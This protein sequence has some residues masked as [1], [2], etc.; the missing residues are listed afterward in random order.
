MNKLEKWGNV[1]LDK[2]L[3]ADFDD[4]HLSNHKSSIVL[5]GAGDMG[6]MAVNLMRKK[7]ISVEYVVDKNKTGMLC[8]YEIKS[9]D[10]IPESDKENFLFL[11][12]IVTLPLFAVEEELKSLGC[13]HIKHFYMFSQLNFRKLMPNGW[14]LKEPT[15]NQIK[16]IRNIIHNLSH[17]EQSVFDY[18]R[19]LWWRLRWVEKVYPDVLVLKQ[20]K[21][22]S[23]LSFPDLINNEVFLDGGAHFGTAISSFLEYTSNSYDKIYAFEPDPYNYGRLVM[24]GKFEQVDVIVERK[25]L[26]DKNSKRKFNAYLGYASRINNGGEE[27]VHTT[28][29]DSLSICCPTIVKLHV[30]G[31]ELKALAGGQKLLNE[32]RPIVMVMADHS[33][34]GLYDIPN[35]LIKMTNYKLYFNYHD[36]C[37]NTSI[38]YAYPLERLR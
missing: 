5:Y 2:I 25:A 9:P 28:K 22:F 11:I 17:D 20:N 13:V 18:L 8:G 35:I 31:D 29:I 14:F 10:E 1:E 34:D 4:S 33:V 27:V 7:K 23:A 16:K 6:G 12:C 37:G 21:Y 3:T 26:Y 38:F 19:F 30:E 24:N 36:Y 15:K 32:C